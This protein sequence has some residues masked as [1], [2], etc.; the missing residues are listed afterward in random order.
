MKKIALILLAALTLAACE[1]DYTASINNTRWKYKL[2]EGDH[3]LIYSLYLGNG[4]GELT[5]TDKMTGI[6]NDNR[7]YRVIDYVLNDETHG[8]ITYY[9]L[10]YYDN[11][12]WG[13]YGDTTVYS[14]EIRAKGTKIALGNPY[15]YATLELQ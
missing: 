10:N 15:D 2:V 11:P 12:Q 1:K 13:H 9:D 6:W 8:R 5:V 14:F 3:T 4:T 7:R